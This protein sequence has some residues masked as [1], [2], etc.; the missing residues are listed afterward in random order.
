MSKKVFINNFDNQKKYLL[1]IIIYG[2]I[3]V[4]KKFYFNLKKKVNTD[5]FNV[6]I[7]NNNFPLSDLK[8][9]DIYYQKLSIKNKYTYINTYK[10]IGFLN[11]F[12]FIEKLFSL[13]YKNKHMLLFNCE[14]DS[15]IKTKI[16]DQ[17]LNEIEN[18]LEDKCSYIF[19]N[20]EY[21]Q[22]IADQNQKFIKMINYD[23]NENMTHVQ[24]FFHHPYKTKDLDRLLRYKIVKKTISDM[25][26]ENDNLYLANKGEKN[27]FIYNEISENLDLLKAKNFLEYFFYKRMQ[28][29][30]YQNK[31]IRYNKNTSFEDFLKLKKTFNMKKLFIWF[32]FK[33]NFSNLINKNIFFK[34]E[35]IL[36]LFIKKTI[37]IFYKKKYENKKDFNIILYYQKNK[38]EINRLSKIIYYKILNK[39][40]TFS[41]FKIK[42]EIKKQIKIHQMISVNETRNIKTI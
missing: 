39:N 17:H 7:V 25:I 20:N 26:K 10:N 11:S 15:F 22:K 8:Q 16:T 18:K 42:K 27:F 38:T 36:F 3:R 37:K 19:F 13:H 40:K 5:L 23:Q 9:D 29:F 41:S 33:I 4:F 31:N 34:D 2:N 1:L 30:Y 32:I 14:Y 6:V 21:W 28:Y 35:N 24:C 12:I